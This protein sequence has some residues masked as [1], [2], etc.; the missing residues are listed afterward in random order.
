MLRFAVLGLVAGVALV[1]T[2]TKWRAGVPAVEK[3]EANK[4]YRRAEPDD[5]H[6]GNLSDVRFLL[7]TRSN[8][9]DQEHYRL[10]PGNL[11]NL[12]ESPLDPSLPTHMMYHGFN[13]HG[14]CGWIR[15]AKTSLLKLYNCNVISI[16]WQTL[17][18]SPWYNL[19]FENTFKIANY[20]ADLID[21]INTEKGLQPSQIHIVGHSLGAQ[22]AGL[23][24]KRVRSGQIA[25]ITGL[26][27]AGPL[28][29]AKDSEHRIDKSDAGFVDVIH[30]NGGSI[31]DGC[32]ALFEPVGHVDFFPNGG[33]HQ[34]G[35]EV[36][37]GSIIDDW[38]D[39][40]EG[41]SHNRVTALWVESIS[42]FDPGRVFKSWPCS[43]YESYMDGLCQT[44]G[45]GC[46]EMGF[47]AAQSLQGE[48]FLRTNAESPF[49]R[50]DEQSS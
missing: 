28:F 37:N 32:I 21:W 9:G 14:E 41:C 20:T 31:L 27:P 43:D 11:T 17:V 22:A 50:G 1:V 15:R 40:F 38:T 26:D 30:A 46:L 12:N 36:V 7:W 24:G 47:H 10:L 35:C 4:E 5:G 42:A 13:D 49:A 48:Y 8:P 39:L 6:L 29:Y 19:A 33:H 16:D 25:R 2:V 34:S 44:C 45:K 23:T 3:N 18:P